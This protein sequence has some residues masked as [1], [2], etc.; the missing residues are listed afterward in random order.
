M[1]EIIGP[2]TP[3]ASIEIKCFPCKISPSIWPYNPDFWTCPKCSSTY[4]KKSLFD[5]VK[6][7]EKTS[8]K[9]DMNVK[10]FQGDQEAGYVQISKKDY[11]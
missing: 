8:V 6:S 5:R 4:I 2:S 1:T 11:V 9:Y 3:Y 10:V 7:F